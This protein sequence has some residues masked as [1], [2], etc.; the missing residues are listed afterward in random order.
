MT[1]PF[2]I[3]QPVTHSCEHHWASRHQPDFPPQMYWIRVCT[4]C[5][6]IDGADLV[7]QLGP[8]APVVEE[9]LTAATDTARQRGNQLGAIR[10]LLGTTY[11]AAYDL[12]ADVL[13]V[14]DESLPPEV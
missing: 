10:A 1:F 6:R 8:E 13:A 11:E 9:M 14:L 3:D 12:A 7:A 5:G 2:G 4:L